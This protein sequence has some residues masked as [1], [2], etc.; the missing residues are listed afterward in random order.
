MLVLV[1][2]SAYLYLFSSSYC[3]AKEADFITAW[4]HGVLDNF[5]VMKCSAG[6]QL[7]ARLL[8][9]ADPAF[10][11]EGSAKSEKQAWATGVARLRIAVLGSSAHALPLRDSS[12]RLTNP[13]DALHCRPARSA[14]TAG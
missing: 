9:V 6:L 8:R 10:S 13:S 3:H 14:P 4:Y 12:G 1:L 7:D 11:R 2:I 5:R